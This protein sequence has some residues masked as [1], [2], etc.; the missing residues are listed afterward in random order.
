MEHDIYIMLQA[1]NEKLDYLIEKLHEAESKA[2][3][4][5]PGGK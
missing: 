4:E 3:G 1:I 5:K 2:K